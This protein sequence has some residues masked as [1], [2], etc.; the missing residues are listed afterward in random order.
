MNG[1][2]FYFSAVG[3]ML[4]VYACCDCCCCLC[5][6]CSWGVLLPFVGIMLEDGDGLRRVVVVV[7]AMAINK[8]K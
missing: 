3:V 1:S 5:V 4:V 7:V 2:F 6:G 8:R